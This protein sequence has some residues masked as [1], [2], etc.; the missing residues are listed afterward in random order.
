MAIHRGS[1][2]HRPLTDHEKGEFYRCLARMRVALRETVRPVVAALGGPTHVRPGDPGNDIAVVQAITAAITV[3]EAMRT[4]AVYEAGA[5]GAGYPDIGAAAG[6]SRQAARLQWPG[7]VYSKGPTRRC[8]LSSYLKKTVPSL[9]DIDCEDDDADVSYRLDF[10]VAPAGVHIRG[11]PAHAALYRELLGKSALPVVMHRGKIRPAREL[12]AVPRM[13]DPVKNLLRAQA[14]H[15]SVA[16]MRELAWRFEADEARLGPDARWLIQAGAEMGDRHVAQVW[17]R[18]LEQEGRLPDLIALWQKLA[19]AGD[20]FACIELSDIYLRLGRQRSA[21]AVWRPLA[22]AGDGF[23]LRAFAETLPASALVK[24]AIPVFRRVYQ[25][26]R[27]GKPHDREPEG[28]RE[29]CHSLIDR[30]TEEG[31]DDQVLSWLRLTAR[32]DPKA[33]WALDELTWRLERTGHLGEAEAWLRQAID[34]QVP[35]APEKLHQFLLRADR[36]DEADTLLRDPSLGGLAAARRS[37]LR[38]LNNAADDAQLSIFANTLIAEG[39]PR[40]LAEYAR[41]LENDGARDTAATMWRAAAEH[42]DFRARWEAARLMNANGQGD[43]AEAWLRDLIRA[44]QTPIA[45]PDKADF[46]DLPRYSA[47]LVA[48]HDRQVSARQA[49]RVLAALL[50]RQGRTEEALTLL[51]RTADQGDK[52]AATDLRAMITRSRRDP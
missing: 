42:G 40:E 44:G 51:R 31:H 24:E 32:A 48:G 47:Q 26:L 4:E 22:T 2:G 52:H 27:E 30:L 37:L 14:E 39:N 11:C 33:T 43:E 13:D 35:H 49:T 10:K 50:K 6:I 8:R 21:A 41:Q 23:A 28:W 16:A 1:T 12:P 7:A 18:H 19:A 36:T 9:P 15:G 45:A 20:R 29:A 17:A 34:H 46:D 3:L 25:H 38:R 5:R